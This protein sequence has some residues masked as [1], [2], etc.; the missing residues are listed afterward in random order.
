MA[1]A[2]TEAAANEA[3]RV[4]STGKY[5]EQSYLRIQVVAGG[6]SGFEYAMRFDTNY[7]PER[8]HLYNSHGFNFLV[9]KKSALYLDGTTVDWVET[10]ERR[11]F[12]FHNP[13]AQRTCG[14]G[15]SFQA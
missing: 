14:C 10:L 5:E 7:D 2:L 11:G 9:D 6:C 12:E 15:K 8:D 4:K 1:V 13:M 3:A